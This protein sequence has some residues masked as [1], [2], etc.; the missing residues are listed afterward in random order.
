MEKRIGKG[1]WACVYCPKLRDRKEFSAQLSAAGLS[2]PC[3]VWPGEQASFRL[4]RGGQFPALSGGPAR[5]VDLPATG[6]RESVGWN[7]VSDRRAC[8]HVPAIADAH[9]RYQRGVAADKHSI[10]DGRRRFVKAIVVACDGSR[11]DVGFRANFRVAE[12]LQ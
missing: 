11:A 7:V 5:L 2:S 8:R 1:S 9:R 3:E 12:I 4:L 10:A 6:N